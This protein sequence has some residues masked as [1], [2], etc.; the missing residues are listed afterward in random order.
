[1]RVTRASARKEAKPRSDTDLLRRL[2]SCRTALS[3]VT[4]KDRDRILS[5]LQ[6]S[7]RQGRNAWREIRE[8]R[9]QEDSLLHDLRKRC[10]DLGYQLRLIRGDS[11]KMLEAQIQLLRELA[12]R[13][14]DDHDLAVLATAVWQTAECRRNDPGCNLVL[15]QIALVRTGLQKEADRLA[16]VIYAEKPKAFSARIA[17][18]WSASRDGS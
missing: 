2:K 10:K 4:V 12:D 5:G 13:L 3:R 7:Y 14:G 1:M 16:R 11:Q 9:V 15:K 17:S 6:T 8:A 18:Y